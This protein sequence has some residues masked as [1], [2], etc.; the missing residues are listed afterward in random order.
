MST[1]D[2]LKT[3]PFYLRPPFAWLLNL[4]LPGL[5]HIFWGEYL[6][7]IFV[8]L[9]MLIAMVL[10]L[11][12][13]MVSL[14]GSVQVVLFG[15]PVL[16]FLFVF[17]DLS[18]SIKRRDKIKQPG[19]GKPSAMLFL[20]LGV[21]IQLA[22]PLAPANFFIRNHPGLLSS[23]DTTMAPVIEPGR[24]CLVDRQAYTVDLFFVD[25]RF[26]HS[27]VDRW[28][29]V[30]FSDGMGTVRTG[31]V[32]GLP[33]E[34]VALINDSLFVNGYPLDE[35]SD[36]VPLSGSLS[37][38][39]VGAQSILAVTMNDGAIDRIYAVRLHDIIGRVHQLF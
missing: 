6:F 5:G 23:A 33:Y 10:V 11:F 17:V 34:E 2:A 25:D 39:P 15:L 35:S 24:T 9:I 18:R 13:F 30:Q 29:A 19:R 27:A 36:A 28:Q 32:V 8:F 12:S 31:L 37:L 26:Y 1:G 22:L 4:L 14:P 21:L 3:E 16:F 20:T 38:T 7:G